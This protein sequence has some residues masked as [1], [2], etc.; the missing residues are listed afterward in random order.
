MHTL[1]V[2]EFDTS[3]VLLERTLIDTSDL[4][5]VKRAHRLQDSLKLSSISTR[6]YSTVRFDLQSLAKITKA[7][8]SL[9]DA[10]PDA[11]AYYCKKDNVDQVRHLLATAHGWRVLPDSE[12]SYKIFSQ[13]CLLGRI[14]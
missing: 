10:L 12:A 6:S 4:E 7:L 1:S 9:A 2:A 13:R 5:D 3:Y 11:N 14:T 8:L